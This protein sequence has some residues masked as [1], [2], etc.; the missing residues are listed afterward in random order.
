MFNRVSKKAILVFGI[1]NSINETKINNIK[2]CNKNLILGLLRILRSEE[3]PKKKIE[4][5][6]NKVVIS[7]FE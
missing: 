5:K 6:N 3:S 4:D 1:F 7:K 2:H